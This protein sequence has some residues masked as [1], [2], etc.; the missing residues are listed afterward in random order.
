M[1]T[2][3]PRK[4][5]WSPAAWP[6]SFRWRLL[7]A[8]IVLALTVV[9]IVALSPGDEE[10]AEVA[11]VAAAQRWPE[12]HPPGE[13]ATI[14]VP[15]DLA[16]LFVQPAELPDTVA[17]V[18][19][20]EG[21][22]ISTQ[23]LRPRQ[24]ADNSRTTT[25][26]RFT[27]HA[28]LWADSGPEAGE[29]AVFSSSPGGCATALVVLVAVDDEGASIAVTVEASPDL[30]GVL[31]DRQW[32]IWESPPGGW[33]LCQNDRTDAATVAATEDQVER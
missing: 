15:A 9:A 4:E 5:Q 18:D 31:S 10:Q 12:G 28:E 2:R 30:A 13:H 22:L 29:R 24:S 20:P 27:V 32:W 6:V 8:A 16:P 19:I 26:M 33:P 1:V 17:A 23:M 21:T 25:L 3:R 14:T 11:V 7:A